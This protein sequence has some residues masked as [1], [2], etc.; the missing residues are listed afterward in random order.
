M[1]DGVWLAA[2]IYLPLGSVSSNKGTRYP[3]ILART[4]YDKKFGES[5]RG[6]TRDALQQGYA[7]VVEDVRGTSASQGEFRPLNDDGGGDR[8]DGVDTIA[9]IIGQ[10]WS[11][12][13]VGTTGMSYL[14]ATQM[15]IAPLQPPGLTASFIEAPAV[16]LFTDFVYGGGALALATTYSWSLDMARDVAAHSPAAQATAIR[17]DLTSVTASA[18]D[19]RVF[20][21]LKG[22]T[23]RQ[24][25]GVQDLSFWQ[26]WLR[27]VDTPS[28]FEASR[29]RN[30]L[31]AVNAPLFLLG[32]WYDLFLRNT[33]DAY[34]EIATRAGDPGA[35]T[36]V[37]LLIG[38]WPHI[39]CK[40]CATLPRSRVDDTAYFIA[41]MNRW[42]RGEPNKVFDYPVILYVMGANRWRAEETWPIG[43]TTSISYYL[44]SHGR[45]NSARGDGRLSPALP[46]SEHADHYIYDP[47]RPVPSL[48]GQTLYGGRVPQNSVED[49]TDVLVF[50]TERLRQPVEVTGEIKAHLYAA[51]SG[52]DTDWHIKLVDVYPDGRAYNLTAGLIRA[53]YR[54]SREQ[55]SALQP[56]SIE[57]YDLDLWATSNVFQK[58]HRIR[59]EIT[60]S[61]YPNWDRNPNAFIDIASASDNDY[62]TARQTIYHDAT[63]PS[64]IDLPI[65]PEGRL[66]HWIAT[67]FP[68]SDAVR[69]YVSVD[70]DW[71]AR[72]MTAPSAP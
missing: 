67:P 27:H 41:W 37:H 55:P 69:G 57:Q 43:G 59:I 52:T 8:Q 46:P 5:P 33:Y 6:W 19:H 45:A 63:H 32:G 20:D 24:A 38:P 48:H 51:S 16:N 39:P 17:D 56:D 30:R 70:E 3:T 7:V 2:D 58:G 50:S 72:P 54:L 26:E 44:H 1:R 53:R 22:R 31:S 42:F 9:W 62:I 25:P 49:R 64:R 11:D 34:Q 68:T 14:G 66:R 65:V 29:S 71:D 18:D 28:Y 40:E 15:L 10:P 13:R 60:S 36:N 61:D 21:G 35:R 12:G 4:P 47:R 23:L